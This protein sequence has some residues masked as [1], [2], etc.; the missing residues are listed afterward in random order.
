M[1][2]NGSEWTWLWML[3]PALLFFAVIAAG[4]WAAVTATGTR[5]SKPSPGALSILE[6]RYARGELNKAE[7]DEAKH[8]L[9]LV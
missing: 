7:F 3:L 1:M 8:T 9:G 5:E 4:A 6:A 2:G